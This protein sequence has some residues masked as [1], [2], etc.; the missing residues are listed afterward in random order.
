MNT[1][2]AWTSPSRCV[3]IGAVVLSCLSAASCFHSLDTTSD[4]AQSTGGGGGG[5]DGAAG[6]SGVDAG[7]TGTGGAGGSSGDTTSAR[8]GGDSPLDASLANGEACTADTEC[9]SGRCLDGVCCATACSGCNACSNALTGKDDGT[10]A[11]VASGQDPHDACADET[12]ANQCGNDGT[13][14]GN[15]ACRKVSTGHVCKEA[16]CSGNGTTFTP[17]STCDGNGACTTETPQN[18]AGFQCAATGCLKACTSQADC[19][20]ANYCNVSTG[21]CA[22]KKSNGAPA[23]QTYE[24]SS[25]IVADSVC[26]DKQCTGCSACTTALNGQ[27]SST[28]GQCLPVIASK[29]APH[30]A[31]TADPP[32]GQDGTCDGKGACHYPAVGT[33]CAADSCSGAT[34]T[35]SACDTSHMCTQSTNPCA[36]GLTCASA[37]ACRQG[38]CS[39]DS[40]CIGGSYCAS[41]TCT[42]KLDN[43]H[44]CTPGANNQCKSATCV[45][46][47]CCATACGDCH[48]C[49][50]GTCTVLSPGTSCGSGGVCDSTGNCSACSGG[51]SCQPSN[52]CQTGTTSCATGSSQCVANGTKPVGTS[53]GTNMVCNSSGSCV[54]CVAG[55]SCQPNNVCQTGA[56]SCSTGASQCVANGNQ[57]AGM[58]CGTN[59]VCNSSGNCIACASGGSCVPSS[60]P[61]KTGVYSCSTGAQVCQA[62]G[63]N[64]PIG[65]SCGTGKICDGSGTCNACP[66]A[67]VCGTCSSW[68]FEAGVTSPWVLAQHTGATDANGAT[69]AAASTDAASSGAWALKV[70]Y[71]IGSPYGS[72]VAEVG[73]RLCSS[74][75]FPLNGYTLSFD[76]RTENTFWIGG[77]AW[78]PSGS[79]Q[80]SPGVAIGGSQ[81]NHFS[82]TFGAIDANY[83]G[84]YFELDTGTVLG[85]A[86]IDNVQLTPPSP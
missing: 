16:S 11:P 26:C 82:F 49:I 12:A 13:C 68:G 55:V 70:Q 32:C 85:T 72:T 17:T 36:N 63:G 45:S 76:F 28:T 56:T 3:T 38:S 41:G 23:T 15:G 64:Q 80:M 10:C 25:G 19:G 66:A 27:T 65:T 44:S 30:G 18:C 74:G 51:V 59:M 69:Y 33:S 67:T 75:T 9:A 53:C 2:L 8:D 20:D 43:G 42:G 58:S 5:L 24:C 21:T 54:S 6:V 39:V 46:G 22:A 40:D 52:L 48:T 31:C 35:T 77:E 84:V 71:Q 86:Y 83:V 60:T 4:A 78:G 73:A 1:K 57:P 34:L 50:T 29:A 81:F 62:D 37:T 79:A 61:C 14:D 47:I 7:T